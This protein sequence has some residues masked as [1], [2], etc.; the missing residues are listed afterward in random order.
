MEAIIRFLQKH[1]VPMHFSFETPEHKP[2]NLIITTFVLSVQDEW[3]LITA[4]HCIDKVNLA[5]RNYGYTLKGCV[6]LDSTGEGAKH[7]EPPSF[8][9]E[10][11]KVLSLNDE[12]GLDYG[13]IKLARY[14]KELLQ[15]NNI[16]A[17]SEDVW[18]HQ[19]APPQISFHYLLGIPEESTQFEAE[20]V[21]IAPTMLPITV[22][23]ERPAAF[24]AVD[25]P[26]FYGHITLGEELNSIE[27]MSGGPIFAFSITEQKQ[28]RYWL[29]GLQSSWLPN[30][31]YI[32]AYHT[33]ILGEAIAG[34]L[35]IYGDIFPPA[36]E[37]AHS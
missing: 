24:E 31:H 32:A 6:L 3:F 21:W 28:L 34:M 14:Y 10:P 16:V 36:N 9:Y 7:I 25:K 30:S 15:A 13:I 26:L 8:L 11:S 18:R 17:L 12:F 1:S 33:D 35:N 20:A 29:V 22:L 37:K 4:G 19:P 23:T 2:A 27:G 5:L